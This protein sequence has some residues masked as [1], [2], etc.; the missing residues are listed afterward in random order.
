MPCKI[1]LRAD[2]DAIFCND[3]ADVVLRRI[4][5]GAGRRFVQVLLVPH[6]REDVPRTGYI[7]PADVTA[8][9][10]MDPRELEAALD[11]PPDW[12]HA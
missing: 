9:V 6:G 10:P 1:Y 5:E 2:P 3:P 7:S 8:I 11:D 4:E 12:Y